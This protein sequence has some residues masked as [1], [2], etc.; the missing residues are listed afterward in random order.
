MGLLASEAVVDSATQWSKITEFTLQQIVK[1][2]AIWNTK[3]AEIIQLQFQPNNMLLLKLVSAVQSII[4]LSILA[5]F[6]LA[7]RWRYRRG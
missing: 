3:E 1:P 2:F 4:S 5:T 7:L 6:F